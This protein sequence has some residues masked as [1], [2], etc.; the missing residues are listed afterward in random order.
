MALYR[1]RFD[2][3][4]ITDPRWRL[5][6]KELI[7]ALLAPRHDAVVRLP[8]AYR[9]ALQLTSC[10]SRLDEADPILRLARPSG[11]LPPS[12]NSTPIS[13][14]NTW[15]FGVTSSTTTASSWASKAPVSAALPRR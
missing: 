8:R 9:T 14:S 1:R 5:V 4:T 13:A 15:R 3:T 7:L 10:Y 12:P 2:F 11:A 6:A